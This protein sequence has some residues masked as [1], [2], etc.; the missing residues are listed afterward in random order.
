MQSPSQM[1]LFGCYIAKSKAILHLVFFLATT[2]VA[3]DL[4]TWISPQKEGTLLVS[5]LVYLSKIRITTGAGFHWGDKRGSIIA[6]AYTSGAMHQKEV[7]H[8]IVHSSGYQLLF[9][10]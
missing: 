5:V 7:L 2:F 9:C 10:C 1:V 4:Y 6:L 8:Y 3:C